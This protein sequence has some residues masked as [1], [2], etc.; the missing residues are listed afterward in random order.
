[1][2]FFNRITGNPFKIPQDK[3]QLKNYND[4]LQEITVN[5]ANLKP[6]EKQLLKQARN[7]IG[8]VPLRRDM[9]A[10][11]NQRMDQRVIDLAIE[12]SIL[13]NAYYNRMSDGAIEGFPDGV[14]A[15]RS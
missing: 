10:R 14:T 7:M 1:M 3:T 2:R 13:R 9:T 8:N 5:K 4:F 12:Y 11:T 6:I 15:E